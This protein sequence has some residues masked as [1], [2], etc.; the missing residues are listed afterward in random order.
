M[1]L[2]HTTARSGSRRRAMSSDVTSE[3]FHG[4]SSVR[5]TTVTW[6]IPCARVCAADAR[7][8]PGRRS[9]RLHSAWV[10]ATR[11]RT[12]RRC[13]G[14]VRRPRPRACQVGLRSF[15]RASSC[16]SSTTAAARSRHGAHAAVRVPITTSTPPAAAAQSSGTTATESPA[17]RS[18]VARS[19]T[20]SCSGAT[21]SVGP[22]PT[23][24]RIVGITSTRGARRSTPPPAAKRSLVAGD[25]GAGVIPVRRSGG[26]R[27]TA[28]CGDAVTRN[29]RMRRPAHRTEAHSASSNR[30]AAG[31]CPV[32]LAIGFSVSTGRPSLVPAETE[33]TQPPMRR[34]WSSTRTIEPTSTTAARSA[35]I[36]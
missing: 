23:A 13:G 27:T 18:R 20:V 14:S 33:A 21:T 22:R 32:T 28:R 16:S 19:A 34:P 31:P 11:A 12:A 26:R 6:A 25:A 5:S 24:A 29:G 36:R 10:P 30:S 15:C 1:L 8:R 7:R 3:R 9:R 17:R 4:S 35:G 2:T